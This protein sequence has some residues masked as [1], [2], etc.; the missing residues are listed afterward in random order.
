MKSIRL[1]SYGKINLSIDVLGKEPTG[2]HKVEMVMHQI[3]L[4]DDIL[5]RIEPGEDFNIKLKTNKFFLPTDEKNLA[6]KAAVVLYERIHNKTGSYPKGSVRIDIKKNIP[7]AAG[8]A[9][10]SGNGAAV[11]LGLNKLW[12][13][14][15]SLKEL[16]E[17]G[18]ELG[19][20]VPFCIMGQAKTN[21]SLGQ[22]FLSDPLATCAALAT[23]SGTTL[24]PIPSI[25]LDVILS[26][27]AHGVSTKEVYS[28]LNIGALKKRPDTKGLI[29]AIKLGNLGK[30]AQCSANVLEEYTL[31]AYEDVKKTKEKLEE[32]W[33]GSFVLMSG[34]GPTVFA[35]K[36]ADY[37]RSHKRASEM[38]AVYNE[39]KKINKET[40]ITRTMV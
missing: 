20:D 18:G 5:I 19:S 30:L 40:Y 37:G 14:D 29:E 10:G 23:G 11:L 27:P 21:K 15:F 7:V 28:N 25:A 1:K 32:K 4:H 2:Y 39:L 6:Y 22:E 8:L 12:G 38:D 26:K 13:G 35:V 16:L 9:G 24:E 34:S 31:K 3:Q 17:I 36:K 33:P